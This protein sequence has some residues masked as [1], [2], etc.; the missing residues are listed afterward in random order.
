M[1]GLRAIADAGRTVVVVTHNVMNLDMCDEVLLLAPGGVPVFLGPPGQLRAE[2]G[3]ADWTEVFERIALW[4]KEEPTT[5]PA[6]PRGRPS[7]RPADRSRATV[8]IGRQIR[9]L[10]ARHIRLITA[11]P[12]YAAFLLVVP[13]A[14][15]ALALAVPGHGG[16]RTMTATAPDEA[17]QL[18]VLLFVG[19]AFMGGAATA[20]EIVAERA[21]F[22]RERAA[23]LRPRAYTAAKICVF[24]AV[25]AVQTALLLGMVLT[26][27]P[28]PKSAVL[29]G[30]P[31]LEIGIALW[32]TA[33][34][35][36][37][38]GLLC[39]ALVR[40]SEQVMPVLVVLVMA[41]L[42]LC[43][44]MIPVTGRPGVA[45]LS[46][47]APAR[48]GYAAGA[49][50]IDLR[51]LDPR[52]PGDALWTHSWRTWLLAVGV[53]AGWSI[54]AGTLLTVRLTRFRRT[55]IPPFGPA[56]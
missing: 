16:L 14:L 38:L 3:T 52:T 20:R 28:G 49:A 7:T 51:H 4:C 39:S 31:H 10:I 50:T 23:G 54:V 26:L 15:A 12:G 44:G 33:F 47:F 13:L 22:L 11:D 56:G 48:W 53:L 19:G 5:T 46:W 24:G 40:T 27:R 43:G 8:P 32:C 30:S 18:L 2:F 55:L 6:T 25:C 9:T 37:L 1:T 35:S 42:V 41:Q 45:E 36:A 29:L 34:C 17:G 21:I